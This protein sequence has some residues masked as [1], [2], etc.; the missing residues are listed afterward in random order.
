M[1]LCLAGLSRGHIPAD[2][3]SNKKLL[4]SVY[5]DAHKQHCKEDNNGDDDEEIDVE[6][7]LSSHWL[8]LVAVVI[9]GSFCLTIFGLFLLENELF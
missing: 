9:Q 5:P 6:I 8:L 7:I 1:S 2:A 3:E 4:V